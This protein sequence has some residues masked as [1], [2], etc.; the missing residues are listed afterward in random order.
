MNARLVLIKENKMYNFIASM[1]QENCSAW[2]NAYEIQMAA[3]RHEQQR[4]QNLGKEDCQSV[5]E[6]QPGSSAIL[7]P[8]SA[9]F[10][11]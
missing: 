2:R 9:G 5:R 3:I 10:Q 7:Q 11:S 8:A 4:I 6:G 1:P